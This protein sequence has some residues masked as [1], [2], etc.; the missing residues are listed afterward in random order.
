LYPGEG[1]FVPYPDRKAEDEGLL[2]SVVLDVNKG[3]SFLLILE[4]QT[5]EE[6]ARA[7][8]PHTILFGYHGAFFEGK[9]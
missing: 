3:R 9:N 6:K 4:A 7:Y 5:M 8:L 1:V 2:L